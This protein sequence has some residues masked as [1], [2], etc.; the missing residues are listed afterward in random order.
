M[1]MDS[2]LED[3]NDPAYQTLYRELVEHSLILAKNRD[4][5]VPLGTAGRK[6]AGY[7]HHQQRGRRHSQPDRALTSTWMG[8]HFTLASEADFSKL[9]ELFLKL[10]SY[11]TVIV[12][13]LEYQQPGFPEI[14]DQ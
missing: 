13:V 12:N 7:G 11:N 3:L 6:L 5:A 2:L 8:D 4:G 9:D 10:E 14:W 1:R